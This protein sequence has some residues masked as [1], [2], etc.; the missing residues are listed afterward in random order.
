MRFPAKKGPGNLT[1]K[2]TGQS[3]G[4]LMI[5]NWG[6]LFLLTV[7]AF[8]LTVK[9]LCLQSRK[10][11]IARTFPSKKARIASNKAKI[12]SEKA[13]IIS[14]EAKIVNCKYCCKSL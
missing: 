5:R 6:K 11:L 1:P 12:V 9:L 3:P 7:G 10:A 2:F 13:P 4:E 14:K 8:L